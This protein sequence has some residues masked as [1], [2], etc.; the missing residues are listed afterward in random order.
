MYQPLIM[1][2]EKYWSL[3]RKKE[4][5]KE[6]PVI[7]LIKECGRAYYIFMHYFWL[8]AGPLSYL[9]AQQLSIFLKKNKIKNNITY[10]LNYI[11]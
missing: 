10:T 6:E 2:N 7:R 5:E 9:L 1:I 11:T 3:E 4:K 8:P